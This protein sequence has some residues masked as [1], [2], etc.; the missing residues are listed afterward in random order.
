MV[1]VEQLQLEVVV[2]WVEQ[3]QLEVV[4]V[5]QGLMEAWVDG[6]LG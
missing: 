2:V 5:G 1:W 6:G 3:L 4:V